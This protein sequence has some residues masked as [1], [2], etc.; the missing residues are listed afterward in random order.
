MKPDIFEITK[1]LPNTDKM[2][3]DLQNLKT[4][5]DSLLEYVKQ[6]EDENSVLKSQMID[7]LKKQ[8][9]LLFSNK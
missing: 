7:L 5:I 4:T 8:E 3:E 6:V 2:V 1:K 9:Q